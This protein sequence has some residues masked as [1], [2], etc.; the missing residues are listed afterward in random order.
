MASKEKSDRFQQLWIISGFTQNAVDINRQGSSHVI[1]D[2]SYFNSSISP[3]TWNTCLLP[4]ETNNSVG[5]NS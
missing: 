4:Q 5:T 2:D 1:F 3:D